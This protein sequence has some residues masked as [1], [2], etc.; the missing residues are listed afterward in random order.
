MSKIFAELCNNGDYCQVKNFYRNSIINNNPIDIDIDEIVRPFKY[1]CVH[2][3]LEMANLLYN[4]SINIKQPLYIYV[5]FK[6]LFKDCCFE[7]NPKTVKWLYQIGKTINLDFNINRVKEWIMHHVYF[8][9]E[10]YEYLFFV[11]DDL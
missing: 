8:S 10:R 4:I 1:A 2:G 6:E 3:S 9:Y 5:D 11:L 7:N